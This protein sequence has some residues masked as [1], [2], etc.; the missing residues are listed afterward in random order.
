MIVPISNFEILGGKRRSEGVQKKFFWGGE[1]I[2]P[3]RSLPGLG[4][5]RPGRA[6]V[7]GLKPT[8]GGP[9]EGHL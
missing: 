4:R 3:N 5:S 8:Q 1:K 6:E 9:G 7:E 2:G